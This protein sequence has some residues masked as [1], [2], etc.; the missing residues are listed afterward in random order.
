M[1][2][3]LG[4][5]AAHLIS[6][7][8]YWAVFA[9]VGLESMGLPLPGETILV[10]AAIYAGSTH[11]IQIPLVVLAAAGGAVLGDNIGFWIG[12][13]LG[14]RLLARLG[15]RI[16]LDEPRLRLG[17]YMFRRHGGKAVFFGRFI[18]LLRALA[19]FLAGANLMPWPRFLVFNLAGGVV[20]ATI[21]GGGGYLFGASIE[22]FAGPVGI[23]LAS[24]AILALIAGLA[25]VRRN[26][27]KL[28]QRADRALREPLDHGA[29]SA[30]G[31]SGLD[32]PGE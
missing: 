17:Q 3:L 9:V 12:R 10:A 26:E 1:P 7:Y 25:F 16:G 19:A 6:T 27:E 28:L 5:D 11:E 20:W 15:P 14:F 32:R 23:M 8:G 30:G 21:Y 2:A 31:A 18:A 13:G 4:M 24:A 29:M 22:R